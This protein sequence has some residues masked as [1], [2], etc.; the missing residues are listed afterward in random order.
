MGEEGPA[1]WRNIAGLHAHLHQEL[2]EGVRLRMSAYWL[3]APDPEWRARGL[4][5]QSEF[6]LDYTD[7]LSMHFLWEYLDPGEAYADAQ[8]DAH[9]LRWEINY[10]FK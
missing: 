7:W 4:L 6:V 10:D 3:G 5:L 2:L 8:D 9:F 1:A